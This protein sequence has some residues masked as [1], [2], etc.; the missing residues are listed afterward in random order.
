[1]QP[2]RIQC[3]GKLNWLVNSKG[4]LPTRNCF[5]FSKSFSGKQTF[6]LSQL[7]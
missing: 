5:V 2:F 4:L 7:E 3:F 1:M 6:T